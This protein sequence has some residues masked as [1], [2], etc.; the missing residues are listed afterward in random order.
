[1]R[2][3]RREGYTLLVGWPVPKGADAIT[4]GRWVLVRKR[5][6]QSEHLLRHELCHVRQWSELG[7]VRFLWQ[8]LTSYARGRLS[9]L[10]HW[11]AYRSI[12]LEIEA[13]DE[14]CRNSG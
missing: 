7:A 14:A 10:S 13:E 6:A 4:L 12:P 3:D 8:Y 1:M 9:G 2:V 11:E 5:A